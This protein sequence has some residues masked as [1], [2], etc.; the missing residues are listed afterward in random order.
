MLD[1]LNRLEK[2]G[3]LTSAERLQTLRVIR[4]RL[5]HDH[6]TDDALTAA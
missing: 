3:Y 6:P 4:H 2:M 5:T 1:K